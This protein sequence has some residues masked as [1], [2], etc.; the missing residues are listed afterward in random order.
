MTV[1]YNVSV[2]LLDHHAV[3]RDGIERLLQD[4]D[5]IDVVGSL[6]HPRD[7]PKCLN[8]IQVDVLVMGLIFPRDDG[9]RCIA[10]WSKAYPTIR[11][12]V[13]SQLSEATYTQR[14]LS[15]GARGYLMKNVSSEGLIAAIR[16]VADGEV[17]VSSQ[18]TSQLLARL[19]SRSQSDDRGG[20]DCLSDRE[21]HVLMLIGQGS[22]TAV[23]ALEMGI[24]KK[25]VDSFKERIKAKLSLDNSTQLA[26]A[27]AQHLGHN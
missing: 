14:V 4:E 10:D 26:Q 2:V 7:L 9:L 13:L 19:A 11:I 21:L 6:A 23:I 12:L 5:S 22:T 25:T 20:I 16:T 18:I 8:D 15:A 27:A 24:S 1:A 3:L 17:A